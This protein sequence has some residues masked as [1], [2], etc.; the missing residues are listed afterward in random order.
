M[1]V[2]DAYSTAGTYRSAIGKIDTGDDAEILTDLTAIS[3]YLDLRLGRFFTKDAAAVKRYY[4]GDGQVVLYVDDLVSVTTIKID[5]DLDGSFADETALATTDYELLPRNVDVG[6]EPQPYRSIGL[7]DYGTK[8]VWTPIARIEID[9]VWGWPAVPDAIKRA[10]IQLTG[11]L[12]LETPRAQ[13]TV[14]EIGQVVQMSGKAMGIVE[15]LHRHYARV[16]I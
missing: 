12:R 4:M 15:D 3:R 9:A 16:S 5:T 14:S 10:C 7:T 11:I 6:P 8:G 13:A 2:T 1:A